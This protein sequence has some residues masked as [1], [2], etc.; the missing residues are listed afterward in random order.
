M[1]VP[2][3]PCALNSALAASRRRERML[4]PAA[5]VARAL[6]RGVEETPVRRREPSA[7]SRR[8]VPFALRLA[9]TID[10]AFVF[11]RE[12]SRQVCL[13][14]IQISCKGGAMSQKQSALRRPA[15]P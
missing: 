13:Y 2:L 14:I 6:W 10:G 9:L 1:E 12:G 3:R 15:A 11:G 7:G 5:R 8:G 4:W